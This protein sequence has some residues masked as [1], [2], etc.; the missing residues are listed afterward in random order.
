M[1]AAELLQYDRVKVVDI[2]EK[3]WQKIF[4][5]T[6]PLDDELKEAIR[7]YKTGEGPLPNALIRKYADDTPRCFIFVDSDSPYNRLP[8]SN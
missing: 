3:G 8:C 1:D 6:F 5:E 4:S 2:A 7:L